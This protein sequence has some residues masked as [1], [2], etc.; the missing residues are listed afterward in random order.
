[1]HQAGSDSLLTLNLFINL[2][3]GIYKNEIN[4][5]NK[6]FVFGMDSDKEISEDQ[7]MN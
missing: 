7:F 2:K 5:K 1:M 3:N 6:F 4:L